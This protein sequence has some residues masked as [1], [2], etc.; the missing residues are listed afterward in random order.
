MSPVHR[1][2]SG[3]TI[4]CLSA[5]LLLVVMTAPAVEAASKGYPVK[6]GAISLTFPS[7]PKASTTTTNTPAGTVEISLLS[8]DGGL[9]LASGF[10]YKGLNKQKPTALLQNAADGAVANIKGK[11]RSQKSETYAGFP[12]LFLI[13]DIKGATLFQRIIADSK[14]ETLTQLVGIEVKVDA[15]T[16]PA[17]YLILEKSGKRA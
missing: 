2:R 10:P 11:L 15:T 7:K 4:V 6:L 1:L 13:V 9:V 5:T 17:N 14:T 12:S 8:I 3:V 16:P